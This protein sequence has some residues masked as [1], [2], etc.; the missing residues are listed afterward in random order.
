MGTANQQQ[1]QPTDDMRSRLTGILS[2]L[3]V[4]N[5]VL[6]TL[7]LL[8]TGIVLLVIGY[9]L[10]LPPPFT[11][12]TD[13]SKQIGGGVLVT[14]V[15]TGLLRLLILGS[16]NKFVDQNDEFL[17]DDVTQRL[18]DVKI[19]IEQQTNALVA[20]VASLKAMSELNILQIYAK[21]QDAGADIEQDIQAPGISRIYVI[22][23][24]LN[25]FVGG[26]RYFNTI[27]TKLQRYVTGESALPKGTSQLDIKILIVDPHCYGAHLRSFGENRRPGGSLSRLY[28][29]VAGMINDLGALEET[30]QQK[31]HQTNVSF[32]FR[33]YRIPPQLFLFATDK[34]S[35]IEPYYFWSTRAPEASMP[36]IRC[37]SGQS[38]DTNRVIQLHTGM[39]EHF[40]LLWEYASVPSSAYREEHAIGADEGQYQCGIVNIFQDHHEAKPRLLWLLQRAK[41]RIFI[42]GISLKSYFDGYAL[43]AAINEHLED[44]ASPVEFRVLLLNPDGEQAKYRSYREYL[45]NN[46]QMKREDYWSDLGLHERSDLYRDTRRTIERIHTMNSRNNRKIDFRLYD[47]APA[48][49]M[50]LIDDIVLIEQYHYGSM[51]SHPLTTV[52]IILG[53]DTALV[54]YHRPDQKRPN[55]YADRVEI[56]TVGLMED[57]FHFVYNQC[58]ETYIP[59]PAAKGQVKA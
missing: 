17:R 13:L 32:A 33:L 28:N 57:H 47:S 53:A 34:V 23:I 44:S 37:S 40:Q 12:V 41:K 20:T 46:P 55:L 42:Q 49:F 3:V 21:R 27:W 50:L 51:H 2:G 14:G 18:H 29:D 35:Y 45:L 25:D 8:I 43:N 22:G 24:S 11:F 19:N 9:T 26:D 6:G 15:V 59:S 48:C 30:A 54:E 38:T 39:H 31:Q 7:I 1:K 4:N 10:S 58:A 36:L 5:L 52:N 56:D 16:Y